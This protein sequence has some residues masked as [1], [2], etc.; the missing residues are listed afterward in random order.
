MIQ[1]VR[2]DSMLSSLVRFGSVLGVLVLSSRLAVVAEG[3]QKTPPRRTAV[4]IHGE[5]FHI[6]GQPTYQGRTWKGN[7]IEGL[8]LNSRM[9]QATFDDL[10]PDTVKLWAYPDT[11]KWISGARSRRLQ[12]G[13]GPRSQA[14]SLH[15]RRPGASEGR[16]AVGAPGVRCCVSPPSAHLEPGGSLFPIASDDE[17]A[18]SCPH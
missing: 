4:S 17:A 10:N 3:S 12:I 16:S 5:M 11:K 8:L 7:K 1:R 13:G 15:L 9:V 2:G 18:G 14:P 6:N